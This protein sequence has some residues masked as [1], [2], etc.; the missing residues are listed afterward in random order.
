MRTNSILNI[1][2][3]NIS[4]SLDTAGD[5]DVALFLMREF[6]EAAYDLEMQPDI[7]IKFAFNSFIVP[8]TFDRYGKNLIHYDGVI[9][10]RIKAHLRTTWIKYDTEPQLG[11][12]IE[13]YLP[14]KSVNHSEKVKNMILRFLSLDFLY[15]WQ[16]AILDFVHGPL[17]GIIQLTLINK[18]ATFLHASSLANDSA[19][20]VLPGWAQSGKTTIVERL[21]GSKEWEFV[22]EDFCIINNKGKVIGYPKQMG[23]RTSKLRS[24][25]YHKNGQTT[26]ERLLDTANALLMNSLSIIHI[27]PMRICSV[28]EIFGAHV[29]RRDVK[30]TI[31]IYVQ[32]GNYE[33]MICSKVGSSEMVN[34]CVNMMMA[35]IKNLTGLYDLLSCYGI[36]KKAPNPM[37]ELYEITTKLYTEIFSKVRS[38]VLYVPQYARLDLIEKE[39]N[40]VLEDILNIDSDSIG[41]KVNV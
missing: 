35:E 38:Y 23:L 4:I 7:R 34:M 9:A 39:I 14:C 40:A 33:E 27:T 10:Q 3:D 11:S 12:F 24:I 16:N 18:S 15:P 13:V 20:I 41:I 36:M 8:D 37:E 22:S 1:Q 2:L 29:L 21:V 5:E 26:I 6:P 32:S 31:A 30:L 28:A 19:G 17:I 25:N